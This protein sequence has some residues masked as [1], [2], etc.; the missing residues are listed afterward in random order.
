MS[1]S[2]GNM[3]KYYSTKYPRVNI[4]TETCTKYNNIKYSFKFLVN[5]S[6]CLK[7]FARIIEAFIYYA[8]VKHN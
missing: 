6:H 8:I 5:K 1:N 7:D 4:T 3:P 2:P